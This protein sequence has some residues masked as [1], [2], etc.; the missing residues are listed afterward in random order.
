MTEP[1]KENPLISLTCNIILPVLILNK[2]SV[3]LGPGLALVL[4]IA[5]PLAYGLWD[6]AKT[7]KANPI[8]I[9]GIINTLIT[10]GFAL[11]GVSGRWFAVKEAAFPLLIGIFVIFSTRKERSAVEMLFLNPQLFHLDKLK[12]IITEKKLETPFRNLMIRS[13]Q[14][15][16]VSFF[17]SATLNL[18][19]A[20]LIFEPL[21]P[22]LDDTAKQTT[23]NSQIATM[24][25][26]S[27]LV[28]LVPSMIFL[29]A[30][31]FLMVRK[32]KQM[33]GLTDDE[34]LHTKS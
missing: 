16:G 5:S 22:A 13:T 4:A 21:N 33:T 29:M 30:I 17:F 15:L 7:K 11:S 26:W 19:L 34:L 20:L 28:I 12:Q 14:W 32:L 18:T 2:L 1:R 10:G 9:L 8:S 27:M 31:F 23:L 25:Q 3:R 6:L 24:T